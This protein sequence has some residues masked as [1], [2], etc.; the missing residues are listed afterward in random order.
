MTDNALKMKAAFATKFPLSDADLQPSTDPD[1]GELWSLENTD[2]SVD[3]I[4]SER[5]SCFAHTLQ[6]TIRDGLEETRAISLAMSKA[7]KL[8]SHLNRS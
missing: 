7:I 6:L 8:T 4:E 3:S 1:D 2:S 5:I